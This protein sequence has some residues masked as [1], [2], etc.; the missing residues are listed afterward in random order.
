MARQA[1]RTRS[2]N[3]GDART[4]LDRARKYHEVAELMLSEGSE[5]ASVATG[6]A[7]LAGIAAADAVCCAL[8]GE[9]YR[10]QDHRAAARHLERVTGD[11]KLGGALRDLAD[12]KDVAHYGVKEIVSKRATAALRR[13]GAL[14]EAAERLVH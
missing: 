4:R 11:P 5:Y 10:G 6:N 9:M 1:D 13:S 8:A 2:C 12:L 7:V 14:V 3:R